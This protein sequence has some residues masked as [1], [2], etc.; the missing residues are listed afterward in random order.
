MNTWMEKSD[1]LLLSPIVDDGGVTIFELH[2]LI[3][4][5]MRNMLNSITVNILYMASHTKNHFS[6]S[7]DDYVR[8]SGL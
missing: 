6:A 4:K 8:W 3:M 7:Q 1:R 2:N 5:A